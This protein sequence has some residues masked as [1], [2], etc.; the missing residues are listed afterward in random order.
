MRKLN[1][2]MSGDSSSRLQSAAETTPGDRAACHWWSIIGCMC[3]AGSLTSS[4]GDL[5]LQRGIA[6]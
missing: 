5:N 6:G 4:T 2:N 1:L 3:E